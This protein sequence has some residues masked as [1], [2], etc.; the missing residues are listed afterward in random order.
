MCPGL[1]GE[2]GGN[3][4]HQNGVGEF[5]QGSL[6]WSWFMIRNGS[7]LYF[8]PGRVLRSKNGVWMSTTP[9]PRWSR[10]DWWKTGGRGKDGLSVSPVDPSILTVLH[11]RGAP[12]T[13]TVHPFDGG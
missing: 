2:T 11:P 6:I 10:V 7:L 8:I 12:R 13:L 3:G 4:D 1:G 5:N 9:G